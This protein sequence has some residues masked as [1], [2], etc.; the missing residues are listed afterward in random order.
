MLR[1]TSTSSGLHRPS[2]RTGRGT[3]KAA[4]VYYAGQSISVDPYPDYDG[5][6]GMRGKLYGKTSEA[7][8]CL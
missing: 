1:N 3:E 5:Q 7:E 6:Q 2:R 4:A 8:I